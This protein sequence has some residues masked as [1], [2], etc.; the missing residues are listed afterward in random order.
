M[1]LIQGILITLIPLGIMY[2]VTKAKPELRYTLSA[3]LPTSF[4]PDVNKTETIQQ[5]EIKNTG[6][7]LIKRILIKVNK[8]ITDYSLKKYSELD[9]VKVSQEGNFEM[10]YP[11]LP[12]SSSIKLVLK[13]IGEELTPENISIFHNDGKALE[14]LTEKTGIQYIYYGLCLFYLFLIVTGFKNLKVGSL[15][16]YAIY[17]PYY[18]ILQR[19][20]PW[21]VSIKKWT[22]LR[23]DAID[24]LFVY[25]SSY[26]IEESLSLKFLNQ[27]KEKNLTEDEWRRIL[28]KSKDWFIEKLSVI[29][30]EEHTDFSNLLELQ[31]PKNID[32]E[33]WNKINKI[34]STSYISSKIRKLLGYVNIEGCQEILKLNKPE[35]IR[36]EDWNRMKEI[37]DQLFISTV[38]DNLKYTFYSIKYLN[39]IDLD[40]V[41]EKRK[42]QFKKIFE[43]I[44]N[45]LRYQSLLKE[46]KNVSKQYPLNKEKPPDIETEDWEELKIIESNIVSIKKETDKDLHEIMMAKADI[47]PLKEKVQKQLDI[48]N[49]VL[50]NPTEINRIEDYNTTFSDGNFKNLK[51]L[52]LLKSKDK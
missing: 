34:I 15:D 22:D 3:N 36:D 49:N 40:G 33:S 9:S 31:R 38:L 24:N 46:L 5:L 42:N 17:K 52:V 6:D 51:E 41:S 27:E 44:S 32:S 37:V 1:K 7:I 13:I 23:N 21:Y 19:E 26:K 18:K 48:I 47:I 35:F 16:T 29:V 43:T 8:K 11:E 30:A 4:L 50:N 2:L 39:E 25:E 14:A 10:I 20:K 12:P 45:S 28:K